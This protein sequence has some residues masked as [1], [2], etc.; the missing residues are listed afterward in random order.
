MT[1]Q[2]YEELYC[3]YCDSQRCLNAGDGRI[4]EICPY[5]NERIGAMDKVQIAI[6]E[7]FNTSI[8]AWKGLTEKDNFYLI[9]RTEGYE[10]GKYVVN[11]IFNQHGTAEWLYEGDKILCSGCKQETLINGI[12]CKTKFCPNCGAKMKN[13]KIEYKHN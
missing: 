13:P 9:G 3:T 12:S 4:S 7:D 11:R 5:W 8:E 10:T 2:E 6:N 1:T